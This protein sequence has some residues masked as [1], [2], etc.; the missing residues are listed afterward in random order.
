MHTLHW[1]PASVCP[2]EPPG[3][4]AE[5]GVPL[6]AWLG[7]PLA[8]HAAWQLSYVLI[9][10][11]LLAEKIRRNPRAKTSVRMLTAKPY[12]AFAAATLRACRRLRLFGREEN[13]DPDTA[14]TKL[15][16]MATQAAYTVLSILPVGLWLVRSR[17]AH[18]GLI[19][20]LLV[21]AIW[22]GAGYYF[23]VFSR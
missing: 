21:V 8:I 6:S 13:Y 16:F 23:E 20:T 14:K 19:L 22:N 9:V 15:V 3:W 10:D 5:A 17:A 2:T 7:A 12:N 1:H 11:C 18:L 4:R